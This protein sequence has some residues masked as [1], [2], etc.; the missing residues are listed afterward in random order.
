MHR[1]LAWIEGLPGPSWPWYV[2]AGVVAS[3]VYHLEFWTS[4]RSAFG[5][6]DVENTFWGLVIVAALWVPAHLE[7]VAS[8]A[9]VATRPA[10][11]LTDDEFERL[12]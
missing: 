8:D 2:L 1:L 5:Q 9:A 4:G 12:R 7:R 10:L 11:R 3:L 6:V